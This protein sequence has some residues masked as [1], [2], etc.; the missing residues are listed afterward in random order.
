M[1]HQ[2]QFT[3]NWVFFAFCDVSLNLLLLM[4]DSW[5]ERGTMYY[6]RLHLESESGT[7]NL[8]CQPSQVLC[9]GHGEFCV[10]EET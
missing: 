8:A 5:V 4:E 10:G 7:W 6:L 1:Y 3:Q 2:V 9:K